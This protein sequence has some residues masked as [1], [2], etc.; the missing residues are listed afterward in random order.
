MGGG[1]AGEGRR[2]SEKRTENSSED[3]ILHIRV[4]LLKFY[5]CLCVPLHPS[6]PMC[7]AV[8]CE[9]QKRASDALEPDVGAGS[10]ASIA[11][12]LT[13]KPCLHLLMMEQATERKT[14]CQ[15]GSPFPRGGR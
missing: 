9:S 1:R 2:R 11:L 14:R 12:A 5:F 4:L 10:F 13:T 7:N 15:P 6:V 8:A 3:L